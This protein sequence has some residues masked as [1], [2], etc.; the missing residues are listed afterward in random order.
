MNNV[1]IEACIEVSFTSTSSPSPSPLAWHQ[2]ASKPPCFSLMVLSYSNGY[3]CFCCTIEQSEKNSDG[4]GFRKKKDNFIDA[5]GT[6]SSTLFCLL[7][8]VLRSVRTTLCRP[9]E[10]MYIFICRVVPAWLRSTLD[11]TVGLTSLLF[12]QM[13]PVVKFTPHGDKSSVENEL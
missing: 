6:T 11:C 2:P 9:F 7:S 1:F 10:D 5:S 4:N 13:C 3:K 12:L 8:P